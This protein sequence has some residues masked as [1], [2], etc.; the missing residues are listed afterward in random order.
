M[1]K[2]IIVEDKPFIRKGLLA[3]L[4]MINAKI[5]V[6]DE[7]E[8]VKEAIDSVKKHKPDLVFLDINLTDGTAFDFLEQTPDFDY[9]VIFITAYEEY[10]IKA[11]KIGAIDYILKPIEIEELQKAIDKV[12]ALDIEDQKKQISVTKHVWNG[13]TDKLIL[14]L[15]D[16]FQIIETKHLMYCESDKGYTT[17]YLEG[18]KKYLASKPLKE[19]EEQLISSNFVRPHQSFMVNLNFV[20]KYDKAGE[21]HLKNGT[22]IPVSTRKKESFLSK[23]FRTE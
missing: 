11:L 7:C 5:N 4:K 10:A 23:L 19:F 2:A 9:K 8:S 14:S 1:I 15:Q 17:F 16:C 21:I 22:K 13:A 3:M 12:I 6:V 20:D 18:N